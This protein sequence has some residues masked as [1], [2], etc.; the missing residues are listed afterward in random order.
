MPFTS[1]YCLALEPLQLD[2]EPKKVGADE[3][4]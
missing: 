3:A 4:P 1:D 2:F